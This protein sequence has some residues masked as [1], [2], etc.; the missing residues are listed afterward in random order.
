MKFSLVYA[1]S[2]IGASF[3]SGSENKIVSSSNVEPLKIDFGNGTQVTSYA[4]QQKN[5]SKK[6]LLNSEERERLKEC[7]D[8]Y[9]TRGNWGQWKCAYWW[10][11]SRNLLSWDSMQD[12][13][14]N[15]R[16]ELLG[17]ALQNALDG[18]IENVEMSA[19]CMMHYWMDGV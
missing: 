16:A 6:D 18:Y 10:L 3:I 7:M 15:L 2:L 13:T 14:R 1:I 17:C 19:K 12:C 9:F 4:F 5:C 11:D 8:T